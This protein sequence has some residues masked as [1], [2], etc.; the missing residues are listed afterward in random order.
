MEDR[1]SVEYTGSVFQLL[2]A[3]PETV[4]NNNIDDITEQ[5]EL[6]VSSSHNAKKRK[7]SAVDE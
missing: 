2:K 7:R 6:G 5:T 4:M 1:E 3:Y